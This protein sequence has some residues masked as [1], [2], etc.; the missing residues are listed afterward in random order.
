MNDRLNEL[1]VVD[2]HVVEGEP[3]MLV[4]ILGVCLC[5][6]IFA[7]WK[8]L[9]S[10]EQSDQSIVPLEAVNDELPTTASCDTNDSNLVRSTLECLPDEI[11]LDVISYLKPYDIYHSLHK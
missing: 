1:S 5:I 6:A 10:T 8:I 4:A 3:A 7:A 2:N 11:L 9:T